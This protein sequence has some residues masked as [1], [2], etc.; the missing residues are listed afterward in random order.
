MDFSNELTEIVC[1]LNIWTMLSLETLQ[2]S[3]S[4][5]HLLWPCKK[6]AADRKTDREVDRTKHLLLDM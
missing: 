4:L 3:S 1:K 2:R 5:C 6:A